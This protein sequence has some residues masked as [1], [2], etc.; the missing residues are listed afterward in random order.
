MVQK[1]TPKDSTSHDEF[2]SDHLYLNNVEDDVTPV[3]E[4]MLEAKCQEV[5]LKEESLR[6]HLEYNL[7]ILG[8]N[9]IEANMNK[10][11]SGV[12]NSCLIIVEPT[13]K[14]MIKQLRLSLKNW[15]LKHCP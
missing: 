15:N 12:I 9:M 6:K 13:P 4:I 3:E 7:K 11:E 10:S 8:I 5:E 1:K 2:C 14:K